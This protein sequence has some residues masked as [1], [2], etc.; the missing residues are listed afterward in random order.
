MMIAES[1]PP[2]VHWIEKLCKFGGNMSKFILLAIT[3]GLSLTL[4]A[5]GGT[6]SPTTNLNVD[7]VEYMFDPRAFVIP[8]GEQITLELANNG[9]LVHEFVIMEFGTDVGTSF[10]VEDEQ[11]V[12]WEA[13]LQPGI[14]DTFTFTAPIEPGE[15]QVV[16]GTEGHFEAGMLGT[17]TVVAAP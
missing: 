10:G 4:L 8:A 16:C 1:V 2:G 15:Y 5:C 11:N 9:A 3:I 6:G 7:M 14:S 12:Y 17:L 13:E